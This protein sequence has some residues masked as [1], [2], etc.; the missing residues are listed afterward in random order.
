MLI[1]K[2]LDHFSPG[3]K[4]IWTRGGF[5]DRV[6]SAGG[7]V[8]EAAVLA[9]PATGIADGVNNSALKKTAAATRLIFFMV[10][11]LLVVIVMQSL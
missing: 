4:E 1:F 9:A 2:L 11:S 6:R 10:I 3:D 5:T 8:G 7:G